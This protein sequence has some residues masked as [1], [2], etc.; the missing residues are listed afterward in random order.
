MTFHITRAT[1]AGDGLLAILAR[2]LPQLAPD[3]PLPTREHLVELLADP[4]MHVLLAYDEQNYCVGTLTLALFRSPTGLHAWVEDVVVDE[5]A[6]GQGVGESLCRAACKIARSAGAAEI[7][8]TSRPSRETANRLYQ[9][10]GFVQRQ[11]NL[12]RLTLA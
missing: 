11:T 1:E 8:L 3:L 6:R 7:N 12:Y 4:H 5:V 2:L 9:R 10:L